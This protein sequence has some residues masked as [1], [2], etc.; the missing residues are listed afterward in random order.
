MAGE[1]AKLI[2]S[3]GADIKQMEAGFAQG[4]SKLRSWRSNVIG[5]ATEVTKV[6]GAAG[7][8]ALSMGVALNQAL[9][10]GEAGARILNLEQGF[11]RITEAAGISGAA[12]RT[13]MADAAQGIMQDDDLMEQFIVTSRAAGTA[14][15][16]DFPDLIR[17]AMASA[18][19]GIGTT[20]ANLEAITQYIRS[21]M[22]RALKGQL[23]L[24][25]PDDAA[26][27]EQ[28]ARSLGKTARELSE[29]EQAQAR[30]NAVLD[31][32]RQHWDLSRAGADLAGS[33]ITTLKNTMQDF[34]E[35]LQT[36]AEPAIDQFARDA[37]EQLA[38][39]IPGAT[40]EYQASV[41]AALGAAAQG[42]NT[43]SFLGG[44]QDFVDALLRAGAPSSEMRN[45]QVFRE[46]A[47]SLDLASL[48][49][50]QFAEVLAT[51]PP[52][53]R[54]IVEV[55]RII[56]ET[57]NSAV[58]AAT[59]GG[60]AIDALGNSAENAAKKSRDLASSIKSLTGK[61]LEIK[62][63]IVTVDE[64]VQAVAAGVAAG[65]YRRAAGGTGED[66]WVSNAETDLQR[67]RMRIEDIGTTSQLIDNDIQATTTAAG[68]ASDAFDALKASIESL[69]SP[70]EDYTTIAKDALKAQG[71]Y[72][73]A[74]DEP[75]RRMADLAAHP[76]SAI[77]QPYFAETAKR[78]GIPEGADL[79][80]IS[81]MAAEYLLGPRRI[82]DYNIPALQ[83]AYANQVSSQSAMQA[84][85]AQVAG[86]GLP[87]MPAGLAGGTTAAGAGA[88]PGLPAGFDF[89]A[90][91]QDGAGLFGPSFRDALAAQDW[92]TAGKGLVAKIAE[93]A[94]TA[95][96]DL[97]AAIAGPLY[98]YIKKKLHD[99]GE[100]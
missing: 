34:V 78:A 74:V 95:D 22:G 57:G 3:I 1:I 12:L 20:Q 52:E 79:A 19:E 58:S 86:T 53:L 49:A 31:V 28:Y 63:H 26:V 80:T 29:T 17:M 38:G 33:G 61:D 83:A 93:G 99:E 24:I 25:V 89:T 56:Q 92:K 94:K 30:L 39:A 98:P 54:P 9:N 48:S 7:G 96:T 13:A 45:Q 8:A 76:E 11:N 41:Q 82:E 71:I 90:M 16:K 47:H 66:V 85:I 84:I 5:A 68:K 51:L 60:L 97:I 88:A 50:K 73:E 75:L 18:A 64:H 81:R 91:G 65:S 21:G 70:T 67:L 6:L 87:A 10:F 46:V 27:M 15:G 32:G 69:L 44:L 35:Y 59:K 4:E 77:K 37:A 40:K 2:V 36:K 100:L 42:A 43:T 14:I 23:G 62:M 72:H 55:E